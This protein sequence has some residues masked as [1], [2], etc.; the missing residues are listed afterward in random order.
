MCLDNRCDLCVA[1]YSVGDSRLAF[2]PS[3]WIGE[4]LGEVFGDVENVLAFEAYDILGV[5]LNR[6]RFPCSDETKV[7]QTEGESVDLR[8]IAGGLLSGVVDAGSCGTLSEGLSTCSLDRSAN[9]LGSLLGRNR[10]LGFSRSAPL[11][12]DGVLRIATSGRYFLPPRASISF[13]TTTNQCPI[14]S[15]LSIT[16]R[17]FDY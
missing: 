16:S 13:L 14:S 10:L 17:K 4:R 11:T 3:S 12:S 9:W 8:V 7:L 1:K 2:S 15:G 6:S 5:S